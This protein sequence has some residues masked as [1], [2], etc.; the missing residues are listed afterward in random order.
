MFH[1]P[2]PSALTELPLPVSRIGALGKSLA[3]GLALTLGSG[4]CST[5]WEP[6][7]GRPDADQEVAPVTVVEPG[8]QDQEVQLAGTLEERYPYIRFLR[9]GP[10]QITAFVATPA[11]MGAQVSGILKKYCTCL[12]GEGAATLEVEAN[13]GMVPGGNAEQPAWQVQPGWKPV[14][15]VMVAKGREDQIEEILEFID[16]FYNSTPQ[17]E[18]Q[19]QVVEVTNSDSFERGIV[20]STGA[21]LIRIKGGR[22]KRGSGPFLRGMGGSFSTST[23]QNFAGTSGSGSVLEL[24]LLQNEI[25]LQAFLQLLA[26]DDNVDIVSKPSVMVRNGIT[27]SVDST[28]MVPVLDTTNVGATGVSTQ[29]LKREKVGVTLNVIPYLMGDDTI[30]LVIKANVS[31]LGRNLLLTTD[32]NG[33]PIFSPSINTRTAQT[34]VYVRD[35]Q[36]VVIGGLRLK[37]SRKTV[38]K[39]PILGDLPI[40][41]YVFSS[42][43]TEDVETEVIFL[44][45]PRVNMQT[46]AI[47]AF[48]ELP[49]GEIF[50]PFEED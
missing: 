16:L 34:Q 18:I 46:S 7:G 47:S 38:N 24:A 40:L 33:N 32:I 2:Y 15:D 49:G 14:E 17:I 26:T 37:E 44:I 48:S 21:P 1:R 28:E 13:G 10:D 42:E 19:A 29:K 35:G 8:G 27:A 5:I 25:Q 45:T 4:G 36:T 6:L 22:T 9:H 31:R 39:T 30:H 11:G 50:N 20:P 12:I 43:T 23:G 3:I 41:E